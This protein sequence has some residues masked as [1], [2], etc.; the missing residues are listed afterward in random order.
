M[1]SKSM[2]VALTKHRG[3]LLCCCFAAIAQFASSTPEMPAS[4]VKSL[5]DL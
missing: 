5:R 1:L 3:L 2:A 4:C